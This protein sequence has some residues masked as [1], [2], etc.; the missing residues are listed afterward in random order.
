MP[1]A[2]FSFL[3]FLYFL[4]FFFPFPFFP[5]ACPPRCVIPTSSPFLLSLFSRFWYDPLAAW[6]RAK[7]DACR[8]AAFA[9]AWMRDV[10]GCVVKLTTS[11]IAWDL[12]VA[13]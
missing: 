9:G 5:L 2:L 8:G 13:V 12:R 10:V 4:F 6:I 1:S 7:L 11:Q 3:F